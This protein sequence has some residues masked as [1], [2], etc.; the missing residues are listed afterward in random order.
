MGC[1]SQLGLFVRKDF[2]EECLLNNEVPSPKVVPEPEPEPI[3]EIGNE[4]SKQMFLNE[5]NEI[6]SIIPIVPAVDEET[7]CGCLLEDEPIV[8]NSDDLDIHP[9]EE[10][11]NND[12]AEDEYRLIASNEYPVANP[13]S[14][15]FEDKIM[16]EATY[17]IRRFLN[18]D[19]IYYNYD[20]EEFE[21]PL[22]D[23]MVFVGNYTQDVNDLKNIL[24]EK[25]LT[26]TDDTLYMS[27]MTE[28]DGESEDSSYG[29]EDEYE[30]D[31]ITK[32]V[33]DLQP[34]EFWE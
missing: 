7:P 30:S 5:D 9:S 14:R 29:E 15:S 16:D 8:L 32:N 12:F 2:L 10:V 18:M 28:I 23:I 13:D 27:N 11:N 33:C 24:L 34:E 26:V 3:P 31:P 6:V 1:C 17:H 4:P 25:N 20:T 21:I 19:A 22:K